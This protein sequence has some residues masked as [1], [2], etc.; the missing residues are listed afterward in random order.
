MRRLS[1]R[2]NEG[3]RL[4]Q[5]C[6]DGDVLPAMAQSLTALRGR[7]VVIKR[8]EFPPDTASGLWLDL[9]DMDLIAVREDTTGPEHDAVIAGHEAW[10]MMQGHCEA[11]T[12]LGPA[13]ARA[14]LA[15][16]VAG[17]E[18][19]RIVI[20]FAARTHFDKEHETQAELFGY[21]FATDLR[22]L[23]KEARRSRLGGVAG[24]IEGSL[25]KGPWA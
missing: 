11:I 15:T 18:L 10:H 9:V 19:A 1:T 7:P 24:R 23:R 22:T 2:I 25:S 17:E 5:A 14:E 20:G 8:V 12:S 16:R 6:I 13:A 21:R 4:S 3:L